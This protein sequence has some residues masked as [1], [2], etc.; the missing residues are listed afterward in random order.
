MN[1]QFIN[2][3][4]VVVN[5]NL[6]IA[7]KRMFQNIYITHIKSE[8]YQCMY[9]NKIGFVTSFIFYLKHFYQIKL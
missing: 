2:S 1:L 6:K 8:K 4:K 9:F 5:L 3:K 7:F